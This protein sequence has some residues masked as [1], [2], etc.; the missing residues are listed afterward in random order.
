MLPEAEATELAEYAAY[1]VDKRGDEIPEELRRRETRITRFSWRFPLEV[2]RSEL[3]IHLNEGLLHLVKFCPGLSFWKAV[4]ETFR[5]LLP[6][7]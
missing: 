1:G 6:L 2:E 4:H 5:D 3:Q 7:G